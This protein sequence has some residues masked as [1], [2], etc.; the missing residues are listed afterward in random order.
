MLFAVIGVHIIVASGDHPYVLELRGILEDALIH[1][2]LRP[3]DDISVP[4][5]LYDLLL[6]NR[7]RIDIDLII[8]FPERCPVFLLKCD[9]SGT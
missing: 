5:L 7:G 3:K 1:P 8:C 9:V 2:A 6:V 4:D